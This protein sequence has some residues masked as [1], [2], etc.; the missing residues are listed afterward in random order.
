MSNYQ[1][2]PKLANPARDAAAMAG[3][4]RQA[5]FDIVDSEQDLG[6][7]DLRR[8]VREFADKSRDADVAV[9]YYAGHGIEMDGNNYLI[10]ADAKLLS[11]FDVQD[12]TMSLDRVLKAIEPARRLKLI[13]LDACRDNP[14]AKSMKRAIATR[15]IGRGLAEIEPANSDTLIA[16]AAKAGAV[17]SDGD[18]QNSPFAT[19]L[20]KHLT[21]P[22]LDL[23]LAFGRVRDDVLKSTGNRQEPFV[24]GSLG[25]DTM[26]LVPQQVDP[27]AQAKVDYE[28]AA[29]IGTKEAWDTFLARH[30][31]GYFADLARA[32][33]KKIGAAQDVRTKADEAKRDAEAQAAL[34]AEAYRKQLEEQSARET[35][36]A[37]QRLS[38]QSRKELD[39]QRH[40]IAEQA[41]QQLEEAQKQLEETRQQAELARQQLEE[42]KR[43]G[44]AEAKAQVQTNAPGEKIAA[45]EPSQPATQ[46]TPAA[47]S[48]AAVQMDPS[49]IARLLQAHLK[50]VGC[51]TGSLDGIWDDSSRKA[52]EL[53][54]KNAGTKF[55]VKLASLDA[56]NV[57]RSKPDRVCPLICGKNQKADGD[58]CVQIACRAGYV[59]T[60]SG[61]C[62]KKPEPAPAARA[63]ARHESAAPAP[64]TG[65]GGKCFSFNGKTY[66]E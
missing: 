34:K 44:A 35:A 43:Q 28:L 5:G 3:L 10:P 64:R 23:R 31:A 16:F 14:F 30:G 25:G 19:A 21:E 36:Q 66:C 12:E 56:L 1:Q 59:M 2:V 6:I 62:E 9:V 63:A 15:A 20:L 11:D 57:V 61:E 50:R 52:L 29:Q 27:D 26:A 46:P 65:G 53:F 54:N 37:K 32:Q 58:R 8:V 4:L 41:R 22:G 42:A 48:A 40:E 24:Y 55:D 13:I 7:A 47:P 49:D 33:T 18:G 38:E 60:S 17:A 45:L 39:E 51:I